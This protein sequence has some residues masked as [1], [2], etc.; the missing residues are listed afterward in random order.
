MIFY[1]GGLKGS[2]TTERVFDLLNNK[3]CEESFDYL[4]QFTST[5]IFCED[6]WWNIALS[7]IATK[8]INAEFGVHEG[9][10]LKYFSNF[11]K[12]KIWHGF[13]SFLGLQ[14]DWKGGMFAKGHF[15]LDNKTP[16]FDKNVIIHKGWFKDT[17]PEFLN[18]NKEDFSFIHIDCDTYESTKD[19]FN[20]IDKKRLQKGC[21]IIF[22]EYFG[23]IGWKENE[24]KAWQEYV[25]K[26]Q[27]KY[28]YIAFAEKQ[29]VIEII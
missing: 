20:C 3:A 24:F 23:Y 21:I 16:E 22:D 4:K 5:A 29:A 25:N 1:R 28:K 18:K 7:K 6:G 12:N 2:A 26:N 9:E 10:S 8:G 27:I 17:L 11:Y 19:V 15:N 14:E 13:D